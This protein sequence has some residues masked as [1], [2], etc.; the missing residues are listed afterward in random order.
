MS[1]IMAR[2]ATIDDIS[3]IVNIANL[4]RK[5]E[6]NNHGFL[7]YVLSEERYV[8]RL[9]DFFIVAEANNKILGFHLGY[10]MTTL[11]ELIAGDE[12]WHIK[13]EIEQA[14][15]FMGDENF[16]FC[17]Q[18]AVL[19]EHKHQGVGVMLMQAISQTMKT[20]NIDRQVAYIMHEPDNNTVSQKFSLQIG[21][22]FIKPIKLPDN[23]IW[24]MYIKEIS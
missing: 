11:K 15:N 18:I 5:K 7:T 21:F 8:K 1:Q 23:T 17:D 10:S 16:I 4:S 6:S 9:N 12:V 19:A 24:G 14:F 13:P 3:S 22:K 20:Q 2:V